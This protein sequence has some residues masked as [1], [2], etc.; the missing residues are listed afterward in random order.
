MAN[1]VIA[2]DADVA[3]KTLKKILSQ[4]GHNIVA[5]ATNG[6]EAI[7]AYNQFKPDLMTLDIEMP[8]MDGITALKKIM[9]TN[10]SAK[11]IML[12]MLDKKDKIIE[13]INLGAK[14]YII[15]PFDV[16]KLLQVLNHVLIE[17]KPGC[18]YRDTCLVYKKIKTG[19]I[20][21]IFSQKYCLGEDYKVCEIRKL[22]IINQ[23]IP[24]TLLPDGTSI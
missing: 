10:P 5:L 17:T 2:D 8:G 4:N 16:S 23:T 15:K 6:V 18:E 24:F 13:A 3:R 9:E 1:I 12:T 20:D 14:N 22:K 7:L 11:I 21:I 19:S